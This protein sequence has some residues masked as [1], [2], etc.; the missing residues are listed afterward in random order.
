MEPMKRKGRKKS[1]APAPLERGEFLR[2]LED[3]IQ[4]AALV[5]EDAA[6]NNQNM[7]QFQEASEAWR[8]AQGLWLQ[9][10][11]NM[12]AEKAQAVMVGF[13][14]GGELNRWLEE[15]RPGPPPTVLELYKKPTP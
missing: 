9:A 4:Q 8:Q 14:T 12:S 15:R 2:K 3:A 1:Q 13:A 6:L 7:A 10:S 11:E 5:M